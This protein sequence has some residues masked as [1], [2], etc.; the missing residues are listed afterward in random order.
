MHFLDTSMLVAALFNEAATAVV[1]AW[2][3]EQDPADLAISE[4]TIAE[5][6]S[7][8]AI[9]VSTRQITLERRAAALAIS[10]SS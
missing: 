9:K 6:S 2:L 4:W 3:A 5:M 8:F 10:T 1:Q 7:A